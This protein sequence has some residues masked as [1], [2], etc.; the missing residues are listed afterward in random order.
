MYYVI[1]GEMNMKYFELNNG[2]KMPV[3]G[4][5]TF[6]LSPSDAEEAVYNALEC[7]YRLIDTANAYMN[8][9]A[10]GRGIKRSGV[11]REEIFL[12]S[13]LW[14]TVY[15]KD[16]A[17]DEMLERLD[18]DYVDLLLLHQPAGDYMAGYRLMEKA[19][20]EGKVKSIG[21]SNF[22]GEPLKEILANCEIMPTVIQVEAH[23]YYSQ[24]ELK[25]ILKEN[26]IHI[27]AW[28]PL[29]HGDKSLLEET[30]FAELGKKYGKTPA[31][32]ILKWHVQ[33][34]NIV[35]P[36]SKNKEHIK[37]NA[38]IFDFEL[39]SDEMDKI[40][41]LDKNTRYYIPSPELTASYAKMELDPNKD[42]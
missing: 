39:T 17:V 4:L 37:D 10:V 36:G 41:K 32:I 19:V 2:E 27:Q 3:I 11:Q 42:I 20:K 16:T 18:V 6:L 33:S 40:N 21:L 28:Y 1:K 22:E 14:P 15:T 8:E 35:I 30:I 7:G 31:Q 24:N 34:G 13:K 25:E 9:R 29:G 38:D 26:N 12:E 23:P 5:G